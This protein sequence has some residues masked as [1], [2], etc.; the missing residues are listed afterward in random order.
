MPSSPGGV[1]D[2]PADPPAGADPFLPPVPAGARGD[3]PANSQSHSPIH[4]ELTPDA[5]VTIGQPQQISLVSAKGTDKLQERDPFV[6]SQ[7]PFKG[8]NAPRRD[9]QFI[10]LHESHTP[11][12]SLREVER[13]EQ[14]TLGRAECGYHFVIGNGKGSADG[15]IQASDRW[16]AQKHG[17][18]LSGIEVQEYNLQGIGI[19]LIGD[20]QKTP[21]TDRQLQATRQLVATLMQE[22]QI[23]AYR[24]LMQGEIQ[25]ADARSS[26]S[27]TLF[28]IESILAPEL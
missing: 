12:G 27:A 14:S 19:C 1:Y 22:Y 23:P 21:P 6:A 4:R 7:N 24:V 15:A 18:H 2:P 16:F 9:F 25:P 8:V 20:F 3:G 11:S 10:I 28:R 5:T 17:A 13:R 26:T